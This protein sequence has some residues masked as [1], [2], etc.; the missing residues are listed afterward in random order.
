MK[1]KVVVSGPRGIVREEYRDEGPS[2]AVNCHGRPARIVMG[3]KV[4]PLK[5]SPR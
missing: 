5:L 1:R 2:R 3:K 4:G